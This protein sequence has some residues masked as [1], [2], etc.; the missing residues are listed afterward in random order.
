MCLGGSA[1]SGSQATQFLESSSK[2][3]GSR[4]GAP[5]SQI[6]GIG[7]AKREQISTVGDSRRVR[8]S[9]CFRARPGCWDSH[10]SDLG[11]SKYPRNIGILYTLRVQ[12]DI[13]E[14]QHVKLAAE[15]TLVV[16]AFS[17]PSPGSSEPYSPTF[18][19]QDLIAHMFLFDRTRAC[20][21]PR[22]GSRECI[23]TRRK[24]ATSSS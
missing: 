18:Q 2:H 12:V 20:Q 3:A 10:E 16:T 11:P 14:M 8:V 24:D 6:R 4:A 5:S 19:G 17:E 13:L 15:G 22:R 1:G 21:E 23:A 9:D 7:C